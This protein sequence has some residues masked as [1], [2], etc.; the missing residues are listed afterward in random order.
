MI[1]VP[2]FIFLRTRKTYIILLVVLFYM[3]TTFGS[4]GQPH[5]FDNMLS[6]QFLPDF[7]QVR[8]KQ[9]P[10]TTSQ[11]QSTKKAF[12]VPEEPIT[13]KVQ[14]SAH[15]KPKTEVSG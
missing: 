2:D 11:C 5:G 4:W 8:V 14:V 13:H 1:H 12:F 6:F 15:P 7:R 3:D 10:K 9:R